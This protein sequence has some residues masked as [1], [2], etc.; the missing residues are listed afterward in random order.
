MVNDASFARAPWLFKAYRAVRLMD[1][2]TF[3]E[4]A[5]PQDVNMVLLVGGNTKQ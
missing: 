1:V 2:N 4:P 5:Y 3:L